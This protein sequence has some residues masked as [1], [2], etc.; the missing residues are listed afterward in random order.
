MRGRGKSKPIT[1]VTFGDFAFQARAKGWGAK[2][3]EAVDFTD[4]S[5]YRADF[6]KRVFL[7]A[8]SK[9]V[10]PYRKLLRLYLRWADPEAYLRACPREAR[11]SNFKP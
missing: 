9:S 11:E 4:G 1:T 2:E 6:A 8:W 3:V 5:S 10:I 7:S